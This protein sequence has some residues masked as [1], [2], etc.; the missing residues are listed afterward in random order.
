MYKQSLRNE[1]PCNLFP[2]SP[3]PYQE[4]RWQC[5]IL[6]SGL[7]LCQHHVNTLSL[8]CEQQKFNQTNSVL[9]FHLQ[10]FWT[11]GGERSESIVLNQERA[12]T[13]GILK[14][15]AT[16]VSRSAVAS[17]KQLCSGL[18][19]TSWVYFARSYSHYCHLE[20]L[21]ESMQ[22]RLTSRQK[23]GAL[24]LKYRSKN[25]RENHRKNRPKWV[26]FSCFSYNLPTKA[27]LKQLQS[28]IFTDGG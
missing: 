14:V 23:I 7:T 6:H 2:K 18:E 4:R 21:A 24:P 22:G 9:L 26:V 10:K 1:Q 20:T 17:P 15:Y 5:I 3:E 12:F 19:M 13:N 27:H 25:E 11:W 16:L 28:A 8:Y